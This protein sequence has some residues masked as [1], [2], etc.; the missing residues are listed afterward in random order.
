VAIGTVKGD[1]HDI[2]KNLVGMM[3]EGA[4]FAVV[5]LGVD[6]SPERFV[7]AAQRPDVDIVAMSALITTTL[8]AM[9]KTVVAL[10]GAGVRPRVKV[11]VGGAPVSEGFSTRIGADGYA[12]D[13]SSAVG[14]AKRLLA[15]AA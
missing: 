2:G 15:P 4:G 9:E 13:A 12:P 10:D 11:I 5:D 3:L 14:L 8:P 1:M 6:V 7:E